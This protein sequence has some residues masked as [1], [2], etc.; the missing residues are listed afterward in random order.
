MKG[1]K[2]LDVGVALFV[3]S[4]TN[5]LSSALFTKTQLYLRIRTT[6]HNMVTYYDIYI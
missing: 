6:Y 3:I 2:G 5:I 4:Q 1:G